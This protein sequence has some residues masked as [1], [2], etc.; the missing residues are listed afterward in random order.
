[1]KKLKLREIAP[2]LPY[3]LKM[4]YCLEKGSVWELCIK[5]FNA[6]TDFDKPILH[7]LSDY[8]KFEDVLDEMSIVNHADIENGFVNLLPYSAMEKMFENHIDVFGL[9]NKD[10]AIDINTLNSDSNETE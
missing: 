5:N 3:G 6:I 4:K 7:P 1:M 9:I 8:L 2:Y 10:L